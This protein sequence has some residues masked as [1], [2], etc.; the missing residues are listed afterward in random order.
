VRP[1]GSAQRSLTGNGVTVGV[2]YKGVPLYAHED[3]VGRLLFPR[4]GATDP[5][6]T[7]VVGMING[8]SV[9]L[10][11]SATVRPFIYDIND[12]DSM[13][14][15][16]NA[17]IQLSAHPYQYPAGWE[18]KATGWAEMPGCSS[19]SLWRWRGVETDSATEDVLFNHLH[20]FVEV[21]NDQSGYVLLIAEHLLK[22]VDGIKSLC[23]FII[24]LLILTYLAP[25]VLC[26]VLVV[27]IFHAKLQL[28]QESLLR[29]LVYKQINE[30][31][32]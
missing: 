19:E 3:F 21:G 6:A 29:V 24:I 16:S 13:R 11:P 20:N 25:N 27:I 23:L 2:W 7:S 30:Q 28:L 9:G 32:K 22:L 17:G 4:S 14:T 18:F 5:H 8:V 31:I 10:A 26:L 1:G 12:L 15:A